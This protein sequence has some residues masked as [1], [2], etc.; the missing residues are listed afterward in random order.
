MHRATSDLP[1]GLLIGVDNV[2]RFGDYVC[3]HSAQMLRTAYLLVG[4]WHWA[5]DVVQMT[6]A[7]AYL[8]WRRVEQADRPEL[9]VRRILVTTAV[10][11]RRRRDGAE[12]ARAGIEPGQRREEAG[13]QRV[14]EV[15]ALRRALTSLPPRQR[16]AV[17]MRYY[18]DRPVSDVAAIMGCSIGTVKSQASRGLDKLKEVLSDKGEEAANERERGLAWSPFA[19]VAAE[20]LVGGVEPAG[21][22]T[23]AGQLQRRRRRRLAI[24]A[25]TCAVAAI[26]VTGAVLLPAGAGN[27]ATAARPGPASAPR[28]NHEP[29]SGAPWHPEPCSFPDFAVSVNGTPLVSIGREPPPGERHELDLRT[30]AQVSV[31]LAAESA[32]NLGMFLQSVEIRLM[33]ATA[34]AAG[35]TYRATVSGQPLSASVTVPAVVDQTNPL[36]AGAY[37]LRVDLEYGGGS[38]ACVGG[39]KGAGT[40]VPVVVRTS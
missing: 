9:Y 16:A 12:E 32:T 29:L 37:Y 26:A 27:G 40:T 20:R 38:G 14:D 2:D 22:I 8:A 33:P 21:V 18:E 4:D 5:E 6:L 13:M 7:K 24:L 11:H 28:A 31:A 19:V 3:E 17:V 34:G 39:H 10:R 35:G 23:Y 15:D 1:S 25:A 36:R 30:A